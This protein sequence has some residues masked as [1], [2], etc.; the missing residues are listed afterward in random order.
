MSTEH[1]EKEVDLMWPEDRTWPG[2]SLRGGEEQEIE[3]QEH[4]VRT[5]GL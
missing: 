5:M 2:L 1:R 4:K 3:N